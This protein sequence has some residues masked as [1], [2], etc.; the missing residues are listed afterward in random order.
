MHADAGYRLHRM[1]LVFDDTKLRRAFLAPRSGSGR[2]AP[3][4][5][6]CSRWSHRQLPEAA[7]IVVGMSGRLGV[8][9]GLVAAQLAV[10]EDA[11][12]NSFDDVVLVGG[13]ERAW[14]SGVAI[15]R[16]KKILTAR[17]CVR[18][19]LTR[20]GLGV[21]EAVATRVRVVASAVHPTE[22]VAILT[23]ERELAIS[24][25]PGAAIAPR[26]RRMARSRSS[27]SA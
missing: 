8:L 22:D 1:S 26:R 19:Q 4:A 2:G 20:V 11:S 5:A 18:P 14:C 12:S 27:D 16:T 17:H 7:C 3:A 24:P 9:C 23:V 10:A 25:P 15:A 21:S 13:E 6:I